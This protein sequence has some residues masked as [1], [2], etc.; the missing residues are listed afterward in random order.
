MKSFEKIRTVF[1]FDLENAVKTAGITKKE[2]KYVEKRI[3]NEQRYRFV[4]PFIL[5][6]SQ[7]FEINVK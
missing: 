7:Y 1:N 3:L 6:S 2:K 5:C 4:H